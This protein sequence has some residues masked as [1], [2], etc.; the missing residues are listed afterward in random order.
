MTPLAK[1][2]IL[3]LKIS[4][5]TALKSTIWLVMDWIQEIMFL[6]RI[7]FSLWI[8]LLHWCSSFPTEK[9]IDIKKLY[10][11]PY[12]MK[13]LV[14]QSYLT[15]CNPMDCSPPGSSVHG[16]SQVRILAWVVIS[17]SRGCSQPRNQ[18]RFSCIGRPIL[19]SL[20][21]QRS[22]KIPHATEQK[23]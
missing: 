2:T 7:F 11:L 6:T 4:F 14:T 20:S 17:F 18:T 16:I 3:I 21:H 13:V 9:Y 5:L 8:P 12:E 22:P 10:T 19:F 23:K 15:L 1:F